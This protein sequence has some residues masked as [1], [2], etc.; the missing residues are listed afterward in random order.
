MQT[1]KWYGRFRAVQDFLFSKLNT[2]QGM[3]YETRLQT[4]KGP[5]RMHHFTDTSFHLGTTLNNIWK[6]LSNGPP[7]KALQMIVPVFFYIQGKWCL[8]ATFA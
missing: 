1:S 3:S 5:F 7:A 8:K 2:R 4:Q 6:E